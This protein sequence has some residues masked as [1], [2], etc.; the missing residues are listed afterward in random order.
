M[1]KYITTCFLVFISLLLS[2]CLYD[3]PEEAAQ[4][5]KSSGYPLAVDSIISFK[6]A[7][8][9]C[10]NTQSKDGA[11]GLDL[12][13]W[14]KLFEG[15]GN[16]AAVIPYRPDYSI[17]MYYTNHDSLL[18]GL[19][20]SPTM[21]VNGTPLTFEQLTTLRNWI[22]QGAPDDN[23]FIKF[24]DNPSRKKFYVGNQGCDVVTVFDAKSMLAMRMADVGKTPITE[25]PHMIKVS[26]DNKYWYTA[27]L[28]GTVFQKFSVAD[29]S[30]IA[31]ANIGGGSWNTF[32]LSPDGT[33]AYV[34]DFSVGK[35]AIVNTADMSSSNYPTQAFP[36]GIALNNNGDTIYVTD[37]I[38][39]N[40]R[41][42]PVNDYFN[43]EDINL[44]QSFPSSTLQIHE[45]AFTPDGSKYF[46][47]CQATSEVRAVLTANDN[48]VAAI[49]VPF[50]PQEMA[51][52][53]NLPYL[54]V[55]CM[56]ANTPDPLRKS[57]VAVIN[58]NTNTLIKTIYAG[59]Q[60]HG[61]A[62]DEENGRVYVSNRNVSGGPA[63]HHAALCSGRNGNI[64]AI[65]INT[66]E[67]VPG[68][69]TEVSVDPYGITITH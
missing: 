56:E 45:V 13:S 12:S 68:F 62:M 7:T 65:D 37:Q 43:F 32:A 39:S 36:H 52:A 44:V 53:K 67:L 3:K 20:L 61:L 34:V 11:A 8:S 31:E 57:Y 25:A 51:F 23:G 69:K 27:L 64:T 63:P 4:I 50:F 58:Y 22:L 24:S 5:A 66:L 9:G 40:V 33:K 28:G 2:S 38:G 21:P 54:F 17:L 49:Q 19:Q 41:K 29:N 46:V 30:F 15:G 1:F 26:P 6:C 35:M 18:P 60:S 10:H 55:S 47:T 48:V 42:F 16:G 14:E 59:Y